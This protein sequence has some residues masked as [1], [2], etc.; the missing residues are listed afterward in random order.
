MLLL[1]LRLPRSLTLALSSAL[2]LFGRVQGY[3]EESQLAA[4][5][6]RDPQAAYGL[7]G[8]KDLGLLSW[9]KLGRILA[10]APFFSSLGLRL[11][12]LRAL[13]LRVLRLRTMLLCAVR[14]R[15][16]LLPPVSRRSSSSG[17]LSTA[18][19]VRER[20]RRRLT[21]TRARLRVA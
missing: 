8:A 2:R 10:V 4:E 18:Q 14:N 6:R 3:A 20:E 21:R 5:E 1:F 11:P 7:R 19:Q 9:L 13:L 16:P 15:I 17:K 12:R